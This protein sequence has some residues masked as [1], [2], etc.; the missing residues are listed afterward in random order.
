[1]NPVQLWNKTSFDLFTPPEEY[2]LSTICPC[3]ERN[4]Q[5][6]MKTMI[7]SESNMKETLIAPCGMNCALC[8]NYLFKKY[9]LNKHGFHRSYC[10]GCIPRGEGCKYMGKDCTMHKNTEIRFCT[11][12]ENYPCQQLKHLDHRYRTQYHMS[13]IENLESIKSLGLDAFLKM[14][15][16]SWTCPS[17]GGIISCHNGLCMNCGIETLI[18]NKKYRW[19]ER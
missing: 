11:Q 8:V 1:M 18:K 9:D 5:M 2:C 15:E 16:E 4:F 10:P 12:C 6:E 14:Q 7:Q 13:M 3:L 17:C 19:H